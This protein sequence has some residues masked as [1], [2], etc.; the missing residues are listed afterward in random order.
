MHKNV[1][2]LTGMKFGELDVLRYSHSSKKGSVWVCK[3]SCGNETECLSSS[4]VNGLTRSCG[5]LRG[6]PKEI[7]WEVSDNGC[8]ICTSHAKDQ[9]GYPLMKRKQ[10]SI[11]IHRYMYDCS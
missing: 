8:W 2:D 5:H 6:S 3:C 1:K 7:E 11:R 10:K 4:M 9:D